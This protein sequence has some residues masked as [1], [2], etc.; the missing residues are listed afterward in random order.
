MWRKLRV[1]PLLCILFSFKPSN[2]GKILVVIQFPAYTHQEVF[3]PIAEAL[4]RRGHEVVFATSFP[5]FDKKLSNLIEIDLSENHKLVKK[6]QLFNETQDDWHQVLMNHEYL[7]NQVSENI[8][9]HPE[10]RKLYSPCSNVTFDLV[11]MEILNIPAPYI[12]S[13]RF[14]AP[15][16]G[17]AAI[18]PLAYHYYIHGLPIL[19][20]HPSNWEMLDATGVDLSFW[21]R[22]KNFIFAWRYIHYSFNRFYALQQ[23][24]AEKYLGKDVP[25]IYEIEKNMR[26]IFHKHHSLVAPV[27]PTTPKF[28]PYANFQSL[29]G[30][31]LMDR[32]LKLFLDNAAEGFIYVGFGSFLRI[33]VFP[34]SKQK[35]IYDALFALPYKI[36]LQCDQLANKSDN[37][38]ISS[39]LPQRSVLAHPNIK[40]FIYHGGIHSTEEAIF[41][42]VPLLVIPVIG[43]QVFQAKRI[44][45]LGIG[46]RVRLGELTK[47]SLHDAAENVIND[48]SYK[49]NVLAAKEIFRDMPKNGLKHAIWWIEYTM[50]TKENNDLFHCS[51]SD[52]AWYKKFDLDIV[53]FLSIVLFSIIILI[54]CVSYKL[55]INLLHILKS[56]TNKRKEKLN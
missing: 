24:I 1:V 56:S 12:L 15:L 18:G 31:Q 39:W 2:C 20:S 4:S 38:F 8:L 28:I 34:A 55:S 3:R 23:D 21:Q 46:E 26:L 49:R 11:I 32:D 51:I 54:A 41:H 5:K 17:V 30:S 14:R 27:R 43:D 13:Y 40:L 42:G 16:I 37:I 25:N 47:Q 44:V 22:L 48:K 36:L 33:N 45:S 6:L 7:L 29:E 10:I 19:P 52:E 9:A 35:A 50:R 53:A